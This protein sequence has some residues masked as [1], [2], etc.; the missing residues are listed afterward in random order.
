[1]AL[2]FSPKSGYAQTVAVKSGGARQENST[3]LQTKSNHAGLNMNTRIHSNL[4]T[5]LVALAGAS[6][7]CSA[8]AASKNK[9]D[10]KVRD[11]TDYF[12]KFQQDAPKAVPA[13]VLNKAAGVVILRSYKAGFIIGAEGSGGVALVK[14]KDGKWGPVGFV[15]GGE[16]SFGFQAGAQRSDVILILMNSDGLSLLTNPNL[17]MGVDVR[18][19][20]GPVSTGDQANLKL[21]Q[22]PVLAYS[23]TKGLFGGASLQTGGLFPDA[24]SNEEY[25]GKKLTMSEILVDKKIEPTEAAVQLAQKIDQY[26]KPAK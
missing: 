5:M 8:F 6:L 23:T 24:D 11:L 13:E 19:T 21:D 14:D 18:V 7:V 20:A 1:M 12:D 17:K 25:Y 16:G 2:S 3:L 4:R 26:A 10:A 9:L 15:K 22:T